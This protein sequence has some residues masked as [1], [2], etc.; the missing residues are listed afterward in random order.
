MYYN[1][2]G[3]NLCKEEVLVKCLADGLEILVF[4]LKNIVLYVLKNISLVVF[5]KRLVV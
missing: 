2:S 5:L 3:Q 1:L 4:F